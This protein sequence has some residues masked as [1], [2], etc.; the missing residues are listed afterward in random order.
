MNVRE[1]VNYN[2]ASHGQTTTV[3]KVYYIGTPEVCDSIYNLRKVC[4]ASVEAKGACNMCS[5]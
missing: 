1:E 3:N 5:M 4:H 2:S